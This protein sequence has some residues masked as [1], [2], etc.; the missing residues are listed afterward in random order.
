MY[1]HVK[2]V[3]TTMI[4][5]QQHLVRLRQ[6]SLVP[7]NAQRC[8]EALAVVKHVPDDPWFYDWILAVQHKLYAADATEVYGMLVA[9]RKLCLRPHLEWFSAAMW[10]LSAHLQQLDSVQ[11]RQNM[12][13]D[14]SGL[15][16]VS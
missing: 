7:F 8:L 6:H 12:M 11:V 5:L 9:M 15:G 14:I 13:W 16:F 2:T 3:T 10:R 4:F 1:Q